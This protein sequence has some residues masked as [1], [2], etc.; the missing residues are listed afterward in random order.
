MT[1]YEEGRD[2]IMRRLKSG[3]PRF[4]RNPLL[5]RLTLRAEEELAGDGEK[6]FLFPTKGSAQRAQ[7]WIE[8]KAQ[9]AARSSGFHGFQAVV[10]PAKAG[11]VANEYQRF[12]GELV[13]SR[14]AEDWLNGGL[15]EGSKLH[16]LKRRLAT[17]YGTESSNVSVFSSGMS[18]VTALLR[19][20]PGVAEG[21]KTLQ[22]EFPYVDSLKV[23]EF[24][25]SGVVFLNEAEGESF[26]EALQRIGRGEFAG[27]FTEVPSNP[28]LRTIDLERVASACAEG[29]TPLIVDDS[30][31]G[32]FNV[33]VLPFADV[34]TCSLT[35]WLSGAGDVMGGAAVVRSDSPFATDLHA[36][37]EV[38]AVETS[39]MYLGDVQVLLSNL[40]G[41]RARMAKPN[42]TALR[43]V[44]FLAEHPA[45][46]EVWHPSRV[47]RARY[48]KVMSPDGGFGALFSFVLKS[49]RKAPKVYD[50][51][52]VSKGPSFGTRFTLACPYT[53]LAHYQELD[54]AEGCG[55]P[56]HLLRVSVGEEDPGHLEQV[57]SEALR[58]G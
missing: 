25:G 41:Y 46:A 8:K 24:F 19:S 56:A 51:L 34:V 17:L 12:T 44:E 40:K 9:I 31:V 38:E 16:L 39:P 48:E 50:A 42:A 45:V 57:F 33:R 43:L 36:A 28:L 53:L 37:L 55:V 52:N 7:R 18:A 47:H 10:V 49:P 11:S 32:P 14:M 1:G 2:K 26:E 22:L 21:R 5:G 15:K 35:K 6:V 30:S 23:Q 27:V 20:L 3:Y 58:H 29:G 13:S 54:W 4:V